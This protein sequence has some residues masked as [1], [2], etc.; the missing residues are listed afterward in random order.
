MPGAEA[1]AGRLAVVRAVVYLVFNEGFAAS[2]GDELIRS[3]LC[4][5]AIWLGRLLHRLL[6][7]GRRDARAARADAA[8]PVP[9][10]DPAGRRRAMPCRCAEQDRSPLGSPR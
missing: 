10:R 2:G 6:P 1:L 8:A 4:D 7:C 9:R 3:D 5:E